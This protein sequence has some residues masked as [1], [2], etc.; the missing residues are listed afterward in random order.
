MSTSSTLAPALFSLLG[1]ALGSVGTL[2]GQYLT[3]RTSLRQLDLQQVAVLRAERKEAIMQFLSVVREVERLGS[4]M[5]DRLENDLWLAQQA[6]DLVC[7]EPVRGA[8]YRLARHVVDTAQNGP[9]DLAPGQ[10]APDQMIEFMDAAY[11]EL[12]PPIRG[13]R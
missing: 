13:Y 9:S 11:R 4:D 7:S 10:P 6:V 5:T 8:T 3:S 1:V 2:V 12:V